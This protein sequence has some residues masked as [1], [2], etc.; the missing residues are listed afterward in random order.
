MVYI[1]NVIINGQLCR[2]LMTNLY[3]QLSGFKQLLHLYII[4]GHG[5]INGHYKP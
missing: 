5:I 4:S 2:P 3:H 1:L